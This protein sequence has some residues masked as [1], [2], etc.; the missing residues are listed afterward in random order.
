ML[1]AHECAH[2]HA[3]T[4]P[5]KVTYSSKQAKHSRQSILGG[6]CPCILCPVRNVVRCASFLT[7][8]GIHCI[9]RSFPLPRVSPSIA[10]GSRGILWK[11][12]LREVQTP[13][14]A[15]RRWRMGAKYRLRRPPAADGRWA[16]WARRLAPKNSQGREGFVY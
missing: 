1:P 9:S 14:S 4:R 5:R 8:L 2:T 16:R 13:A 12:P 3:H 10:C 7:V 15:G 6:G 11:S